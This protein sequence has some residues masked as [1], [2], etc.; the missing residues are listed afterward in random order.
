MAAA[1]NY[2]NDEGYKTFTWDNKT[3]GNTAMAVAYMSRETGGGSVLLKD[4]DNSKYSKYTGDRT[5][6]SSLLGIDRAGKLISQESITNLYE[7]STVL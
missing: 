3:G 1:M 5:D 6:Y 2:T 7:G 4:F